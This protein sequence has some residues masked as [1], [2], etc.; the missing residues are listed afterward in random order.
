MIAAKKSRARLVGSRL[1]ESISAKLNHGARLPSR[2]TA[3][4]M[5]LMVRRSTM[6]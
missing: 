2:K 5:A 3:R 6:T 1:S 4:T